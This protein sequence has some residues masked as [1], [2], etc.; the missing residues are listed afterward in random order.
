[1]RRVDGRV[2]AVKAAYGTASVVGLVYCRRGLFGRHFRIFGEAERA[3]V[4]ARSNYFTTIAVA[5]TRLVISRCR[6]L[7]YSF[8]FRGDVLH[9]P[10]SIE[11]IRTARLP[12]TV[13]LA[14]HH[15]STDMPMVVH[16]LDGLVQMHL[17]RDV[18]MLGLVDRAIV[19]MQ[20]RHLDVLNLSLVYS[21]ALPCEELLMVCRANHALL[22]LVRLGR[23]ALR[24]G[25]LLLVERLHVCLILSNLYVLV[26]QSTLLTDIVRFHPAVLQVHDSGRA[27]LDVLRLEHLV[28]EVLAVSHVVLLDREAQTIVI[29]VAHGHLVGDTAAVVVLMMS[30]HSTTWSV[31]HNQSLSC[32]RIV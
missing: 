15:L 10:R 13:T 3:R 18:V 31:G 26:P 24:L 12:P 28:L 17:R 27:R 11:L 7:N 21:R 23:G 8:D 16:I 20:A 14:L 25:K 22:H 6:L 30:S 5:V 4:I 1:M 9:G 32:V 2:V 29:V 19:R